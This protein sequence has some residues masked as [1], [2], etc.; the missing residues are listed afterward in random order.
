MNYVT[1]S[2]LDLANL[3]RKCEFISKSSRCWFMGNP[4]SDESSIIFSDGYYNEA[5]NVGQVCSL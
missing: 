4:P 3:K 2:I 1:S 5:D